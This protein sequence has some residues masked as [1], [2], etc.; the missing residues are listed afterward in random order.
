MALLHIFGMCISAYLRKN[1]KKKT[2]WKL[3][4]GIALIERHKLYKLL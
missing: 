4:E 3:M 2:N 1:N